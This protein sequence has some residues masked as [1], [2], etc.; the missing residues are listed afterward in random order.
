M[1]IVVDDILNLLSYFE[2]RYGF[3]ALSWNLNK[4]S[5]LNVF[6]EKLRQ[7]LL[8]LLLPNIPVEFRNA[9]IDSSVIYDDVVIE[10]ISYGLPYGGKS[11]GFFMYPRKRVSEKLP[12]VLALHD[13]G[14]FKYFG[15]EKIAFVSNEPEILRSY[16]KSFYGGRS[17]AFELAKKGFA[18]LAID[19]FLFG[20]RR[21][22]VVDETSIGDV[23]EVVKRYN[24]ASYRIENFVAKVL[25]IIGVSILGLIVYE[26]LVSLKYLLSRDEVDPNRIGSC[27][28]SLGGL[29]SLLLAALDNNVKCSVVAVAM[30]TID[31]IIKRGIEHA[32]TLYVPS[33]LKYFD[34]PDLA[35]LHAPKPLMIQYCKQDAIFPYEGQLKAH[36]KILSIYKS[37]GAEHNYHGVF[38]EKPHIFDVEMQEDAFSWLSKCLSREDVQ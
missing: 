35:L 23:N 13:H 36:N 31:E 30:S 9:S 6:K 4:V 20:S 37:L 33:M 11:E 17:W 25:S 15:K 24:E 28:A 18:V 22:G 26:D 5:E 3:H 34:F 14:G 32:W 10:K 21:I 27:G 8:E 29:R 2:K 7:K 12:A 1:N 38:Y 19:V 16:K